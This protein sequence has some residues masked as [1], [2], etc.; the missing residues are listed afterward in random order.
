MLKNILEC[1]ENFL[2]FRMTIA[3]RGQ[4]VGLDSAD[5]Q[6]NVQVSSYFLFKYIFLFNKL[7]SCVFM[8]CFFIIECITAKPSNT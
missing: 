8:D 1:E 4:T 2:C 6:T 7:L 5:N 3:T